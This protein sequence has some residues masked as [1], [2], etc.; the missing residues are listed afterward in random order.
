MKAGFRT[1]AAF[2][3]L[4]FFCATVHLAFAKKQDDDFKWEDAAK[5]V[6]KFPFPKSFID[7][8]KKAY[9]VTW[10]A[11]P[12]RTIAHGNRFKGEKLVYDIGWGPFRAGYVIL[13]VDHDP[14]AKTIIIGGKALSNNFVSKLYRMRDYVISTVD[15][16]GL[17]PLFFEQHLREGKKYK[18]DGW[19]LYDHVKGKI[20]VKERRFKTLDAP[21]FVNDYLSVLLKVR[22]MRFAPGDT[23]TLPLYAD[24]KIHPLYFVCKGRKTFTFES[25]TIPCLVLEPKLVSSKG[26]FNK[27]DKMQVW[28]SDD[29]FKRPVYI[30]SKIKVGSITARLINQV[31]AAPQKPKKK[32]VA[33]STQQVVDPVTPPP[34]PKPSHDSLAVDSAAAG[35][36]P[37]S[38]PA[39]TAVAPAVED[40]SGAVPDSASPEH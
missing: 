13:T 31:Q 39:D 25:D 22:T 29:E 24:K 15:A 34:D 35:C 20:H 8:L 7:S 6:E 5:E 4:F 38:L 2:V 10:P 40:S 17:Y 14:A 37:P 18:S 19:I 21:Q 11:R 1:G 27:K 9:A 30:K 23:F 33:P 28:L 16:T 26:A 12:L 3:A 32:T 36:G